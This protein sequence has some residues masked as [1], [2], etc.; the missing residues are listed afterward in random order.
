M[1]AYRLPNARAIFIHDNL[2]ELSIAVAHRIAASASE[3]I[4]LR[5]VFHLVLAGGETPR[6]CYEKLRE[7]VM[8]W[9]HVHLYL[10]DERC[11]PKGDDQRNETMIRSAL[12]EHITIP[13]ANVHFIPSELGADAAAA[14]YATTLSQIAAPDMVLL[15]MG[16]DGHT[17]SLFPDNP[18]TESE[19]PVVPVFN[20][21]KLPPERVSFGMTTL[22]KVEQKIFLVA[23]AGKRNALG[24]MSQGILLPAARVVNAEWHIDRMSLPH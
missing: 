18:A 22:N 21:P 11:L 8:D 3:A 16:E 2:D 4:N 12:L 23:G 14:A 7:L 9:N 24:A 5:G 13:A 10:G 17:A 20:A 19:L 1:N 15:G 6:R